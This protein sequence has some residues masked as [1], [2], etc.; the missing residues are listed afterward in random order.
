M[1]VTKAM[2]NAASEALGWEV[3]A[4]RINEIVYHVGSNT[5]EEAQAKLKGKEVEFEARGGR[6]VELADEIDE[7]RAYIAFYNL[8]PED[9]ELTITVKVQAPDDLTPERV[10]KLVQRCIEVGIEDADYSEEETDYEDPDRA[11][12]L[13]LNIVSV[14]SA[15][16]Q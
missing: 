15:Q 9:R 8:M 7:L 1:R 14:S 2:L 12:V 6:G 4:D 16:G 3:D 10:A 13:D 5:L 11:D